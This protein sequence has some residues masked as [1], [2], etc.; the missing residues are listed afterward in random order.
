MLPDETYYEGILPEGY[1]LAVSPSVGY[2]IIDVD[3]SKDKMVLI[4]YLLIFI[5][6]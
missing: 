5:L 2:V 4:P 1:N 6:K 3:V